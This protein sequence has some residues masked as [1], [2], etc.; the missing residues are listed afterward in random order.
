M[1][2][3]YVG[4]PTLKTGKYLFET[5]GEYKVDDKFG[6]YLLQ[7]YPSEFKSVTDSALEPSKED[8]DV[9]PTTIKKVVTRS[10]KTK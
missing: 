5:E 10:H 9:K 3:Y 7:T 6:A 4:G 2:L 1:V 8:Q